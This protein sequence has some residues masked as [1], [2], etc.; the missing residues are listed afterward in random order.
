MIFPY[1]DGQDLAVP[2]VDFMLRHNATHHRSRA[3]HEVPREEFFAAA[4]PT[5][6]QPCV[7]RSGVGRGAHEWDKD[8]R[9]VFC[10]R[11]K[12]NGGW[13]RRTAA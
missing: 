8:D 1:G 12:N 9:C 6:A 5:D 10:D 4:M 7:S 11:R 13:L 3:R 2:P